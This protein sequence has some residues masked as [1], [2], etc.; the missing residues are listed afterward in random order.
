MKFSQC[1]SFY[2]TLLVSFISSVTC[3]KFEIEAKEEG[4]KNTCIR[5]FVTEGQMVVVNINSSGSV[6]D[7]QTL[8][9]FI[10]DS[11][12]NQYKDKKDFAGK[13]RVAFTAH[14]SAA[15]DVC[16]NNVVGHHGPDNLFREIELD[17]E[18]G[19]AAR[20]WNAIQ[21]AE[22][23]KPVEL[24]L[25]RIEQLT[26]EITSELKYLQKREERMRDTNESTNERVQ[27]F[28]T[29]VIVALV[30][31]G[32]WNVYYLRNYFRSKHIL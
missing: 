2:L 4:Y 3:L 23:L 10:V 17:I 21:A 25:M 9:F 22:K 32:A 13:T 16:F 26:N 27:N 8:N 28:S 31:L 15:F 19:S 5:D 7:G 12:G 6:G 11:L 29:M 24:E 18:S 1:I 20:D 14:S 30:G